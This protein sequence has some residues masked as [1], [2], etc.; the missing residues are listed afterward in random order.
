[1]LENGE[2][3]R[4]GE[5]QARHSDARIIAAT[6][7]DLRAGVQQGHFRQDLY[8]RLSVLTI[9]VP[10]LRERN[11]DCL[12]L[13]E[14]F[15]QVYALG[16]LR[17]FE[18]DQAA[19]ACLLE[20]S[21]P[22]NV[23]EL[24]NIV[25]RLSAKYPGQQVG[26]TALRAEMEAVIAPVNGA[27]APEADADQIQAELLDKSFS[28]EQRLS[29]LE[30]DYITTALNLCGGNLSKAARMLRINRT[31]LYSRLQ[32]LSIKTQD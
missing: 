22:G 27:R 28:L 1:M 15:R 17:P 5:T 19:T 12:L 18:L 30:R 10:P 9:T 7:R 21:F 29:D 13:L 25:I 6:N 14:H 2:F 3:Y 24:R 8:H 23:R 16:N 11:S 4:L 20:Y 32:R 26:V 31:T